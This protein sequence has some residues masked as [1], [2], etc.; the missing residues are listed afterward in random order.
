MPLKAKRLKGLR[1]DEVSGVDMPAHLAP[2]YL[3]MKALAGDDPLADLDDDEIDALTKALMGD[4][5]GD[6]VP[7]ELIA[8]LTKAMGSMP[9][10]AKA[11][12]TALI[13]ALGGDAG[14]TSGDD[15]VAKA[16]AEALTKAQTERDEALAAKTAAEEALAKATGPAPAETDEEQ[17]AKAME[18]LPE[19]VRKAW[20]D[21]Q[22]RI[23]K[24]E[25]AA[26]EG[27]ETARV[28]KE[29]RLSTEYLTKATGPDYA[30]LPATAE[31]R[32]T[33]LREIDEKL[34]KEAGAEL[35]RILKAASNTTPADFKEYGGMGGDATGAGGAMAQLEAKA[36]ELMT[37]DT[38]LTKAEAI[39]K[40]ADNNPELARAYEEAMR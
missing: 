32:A 12:A 22:E 13:A 25:A 14:K 23:A 30:N 6:H 10:A 35:L 39:S 16:V 36:A 33:I 24:A 8:T 27:V 2:G 9:D 34:S 38:S 29:A 26:A 7:N 20:A 18:T 15:P 21:Q 17:L 19:P 31:V 3:V 28:E 5:Q 1:M 11:Q 4:E 40:A 37:S